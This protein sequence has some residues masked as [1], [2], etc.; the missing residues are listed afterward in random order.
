[1]LLVLVLALMAIGTVAVAAASP[2]SARRLS[3]A[4]RTLDDLHFFWLHLRWQ[5]LGLVVHVRRLAAAARTRRGAAA[6]VLARRCWSALLLVPLVGSEVNGARRW[7]NLGVSL[8]AVRVPQA[9]L[10]DRA[11]VDPVVARARSA[12]CR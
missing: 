2:A 1:M 4:R 5:V 9:G 8:P 6:I 10:R 7:L 3:T 11:R 12:T